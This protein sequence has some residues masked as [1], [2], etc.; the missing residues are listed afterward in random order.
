MKFWDLITYLPL[1]Q[2]ILIKTISGEIPFEGTVEQ[3]TDTKYT[4]QY[5]KERSLVAIKA[6]EDFVVIIITD[7]GC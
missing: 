4:R 2:S 1:K 3:L 5:I 6:E 7:R